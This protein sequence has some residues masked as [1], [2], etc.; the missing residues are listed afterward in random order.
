MLKLY[1]DNCCYNRPF[2]DLEQEKINLEANAIENI[3]RKH[4]NKEVEIYKSMAI[5][6]EISKI[7]PDNKRRQVEDLY[8]AVE[9]IEIDYSEEIKQ[10]AIE[11]RQYNIKDMDSLHLAFATSNDID[12]FITTD[13]LLINASKRAN[14]K[15][16]VINPIEFIMEV[17]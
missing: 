2:D 14:L 15:I 1:L 4:I 8:D 13:R 10:I 5:D 3:F 16:K 6:F 12:Y 11:L 17:I 9:L 7:K